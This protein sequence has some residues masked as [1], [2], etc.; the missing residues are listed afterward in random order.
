MNMDYSYRP[1]DDGG[2]FFVGMKFAPTEKLK[3]SELNRI[4]VELFRRFFV[5]DGEP[6]KA[7][8]KD[9]PMLSLVQLLVDIDFMLDE[10]AFAEIPDDLKKLFIVKQRDGK[11]YRYGQKPRW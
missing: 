7:K 10:T 3:Q 6:L 8:H 2:M 5:Q 4:V 1:E 11:E 9:N